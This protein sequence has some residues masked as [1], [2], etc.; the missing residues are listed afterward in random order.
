MQQD[1]VIFFANVDVDA[2]RLRVLVVLGHQPDNALEIFPAGL[3]NEDI[4]HV[5]L[6]QS[7]A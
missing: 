4:I 7:S 3:P 5:I 1:G 6:S 2:V